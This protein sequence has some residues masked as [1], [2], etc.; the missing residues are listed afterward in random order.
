MKDEI[1]KEVLKIGYN[2]L[3][4]SLDFFFRDNPLKV[5]DCNDKCDFAAPM[6]ILGQF[7]PEFVYAKAT[8]N[9]ERFYH[10]IQKGVGESK[11]HDQI[12]FNKAYK[13]MKKSAGLHGMALPMDVFCVGN[14]ETEK[15]KDCHVY[16][17]GFKNT[18]EGTI[19]KLKRLD[20]WLYGQSEGNLFKC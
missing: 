7:N 12:V 8:Q 14:T 11:F 3:I 15:V 2:E 10:E 18:V 19:S 9:T 20:M 4:T 1:G 17:P 13:K 5:I 16:H 6:N